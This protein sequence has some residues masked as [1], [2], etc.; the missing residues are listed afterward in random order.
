MHI[1]SKFIARS[2]LHSLP[3]S[4]AHIADEARWESSTLLS[5][6]VDNTGRKKL[7]N[8]NRA[9]T[10]RCIGLGARLMEY[11]QAPYISCA[12]N[13][14]EMRMEMEKVRQYGALVDVFVD[15]LLA[16]EEH[17]S[18]FEEGSRE[19]VDLNTQSRAHMI[20]T[21]QVYVNNF[22]KHSRRIPT[23][24]AMF[25]VLSEEY[26]RMDMPYGV[27]DAVHTV[28]CSG[29]PLDRLSPTRDGLSKWLENLKH[30]NQGFV[31]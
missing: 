21:G 8:E 6:N 13:M 7:W 16:L 18:T 28:L 4:W 3:K 12:M 9:Q 1:V 22:M 30:S 10:F 25:V 11:D 24:G 26:G 23:A 5:R 31:L 15:G 2:I 19:L 27:V 14:I 17:F 29:I 20:G